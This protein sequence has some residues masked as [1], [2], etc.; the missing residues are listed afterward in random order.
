MLASREQS[1]V[2][3]RF[4]VLSVGVVVDREVEI[5]ELNVK[6]ARRSDRSQDDMT[7]LGGPKQSVGNLAV[8]VLDGS[9][10][11]L[12]CVELV[13]GDVVLDDNTRSGDT[14]VGVIDGDNGESLTVRLPSE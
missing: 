12:L 6:L 4:D 13:E 14:V 8:K 3:S 7:T 11:T 10:V 2:N 5:V 1:R 9:K